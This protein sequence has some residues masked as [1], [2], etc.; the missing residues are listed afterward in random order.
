M[1]AEGKILAILPTRLTSERFPGKVISYV[2]PEWTQTEQTLWRLKMAR[3]VRTIVI[4]TTTDK[5]D[6]KIV[7]LAEKVGI[8]CFRGERD[9][10]VERMWDAAHHYGG[11]EPLV[12]RVMADQPFMDWEALD[13]S[14]SLMLAN[15]WDTM[16][17][18][19]F[20]EDPIYGAGVAPWSYKAF[21]AIREHS[22][23][24]DELEHVGMWLRRN[25][26]QFDY[27]LIDLPHWCY[28]PYRLELDTIPD[29]DFI[30]ELHNQMRAGHKPLRE[31]VRF[32]DKNP[33]LAEI[34]AHIQERSG[35]YTSYT[36][37]EIKQWQRDYA[38]R[39]VVWSDM[40][41]LVGSIDTVRQARYK[42]PKCEGALIAINIGYKGRFLELE[43]V[44]CSNIQKFH[45]RHPKK[46]PR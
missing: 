42:C 32:L 4:A 33:R 3:S 9:N 28:R 39:P 2:T 15:N 18:L 37:E 8:P 44:Q 41:G 24:P 22:A 10:V 19:A 12:Y 26:S 27:G 43:C 20:K 6:D 25:I 1:N 7:E 35:T 14:A 21:R 46:D 16:L 45:A 31:I 13:R 29:R 11:G 5:E 34:N 36:D 40:A 38:G 30:R 23:Q 17:P